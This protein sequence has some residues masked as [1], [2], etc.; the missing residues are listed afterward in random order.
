MV[1]SFSLVSIRRSSS[2]MPIEIIKMVITLLIHRRLNI[3]VLPR[4]ILH[5]AMWL[6]RAAAAL[7]LGV[8]WWH[9]IL[10]LILLKL[11]LVVGVHFVVGCHRTVSL[12]CFRSL[13]W[14]GGLLMDLHILHFLAW[15]TILPV[16][17]GVKISG[18]L[19]SWPISIFIHFV[20]VLSSLGRLVA[21][22][23][24]TLSSWWVVDTIFV[25]FVS[26]IISD[27]TFFVFAGV[28]NI[29]ILV[30]R[31]VVIHLDNASFVRNLILDFHLAVDGAWC[32]TFILFFIFANQVLD[33]II[34]GEVC[35]YLTV[36]G[37]FIGNV[38][39]CC[40]EIVWLLAWSIDG[41]N[42]ATV[43]NIKVMCNLLRISHI[44]RSMCN[45]LLLLLVLLTS[46][47]LLHLNLL[48]CYHLVIVDIGALSGSEIAILFLAG[49][50]LFYYLRFEF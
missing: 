19:Q 48:T 25:L 7:D 5:R 2:L 26:F 50:A 36:F 43:F 12:I 38:A 37:T 3:W 11:V 17:L 31:L 44:L 45:R 1:I 9:S 41:L 15:I 4:S 30:W 22:L 6:K 49:F 32:T 34:L 21:L 18:I 13:I 23:I 8:A 46:I 35:C 27:R 42:V 33:V 14:I 40:D 39:W 20:I 28:S 24:V 47:L 16:V 10:A 29:L